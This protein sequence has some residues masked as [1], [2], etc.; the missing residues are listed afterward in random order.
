MVEND[1]THDHISTQGHKVSHTINSST[2]AKKQ[3]T[4]LKPMI[5]TYFSAF[6][7]KL[8]KSSKM[9]N[10][11]RLLGLVFMRWCRDDSKDESIS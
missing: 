6:G 2:K 11:K 7:N 4:L 9:H 3:N 10:A 1:Q 8:P 5:Y